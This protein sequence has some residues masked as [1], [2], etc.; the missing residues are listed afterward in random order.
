VHPDQM[1]PAMPSHKS[2]RGIALG[3]DRG[4][5][6][7]GTGTAFGRQERMADFRLLRPL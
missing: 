5:K 3:P 6:E 4:G 2:Y 7:D 1:R